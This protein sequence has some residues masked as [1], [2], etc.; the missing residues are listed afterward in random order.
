MP[1]RT[2]G[3][4]SRLFA[5]SSRPV[6]IG[7]TGFRRCRPPGPNLSCVSDRRLAMSAW[8]GAPELALVNWLS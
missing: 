4:D 5:A 1:R 2:M 6:D 3:G 8:I 7:D